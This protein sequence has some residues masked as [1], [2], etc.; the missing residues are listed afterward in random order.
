[1]HITSFYCTKNPDAFNADVS[2]AF[3]KKLHVLLCSEPPLTH[4]A[5]AQT[6][7]QTHTHT[8]THT[9]IYFHCCQGGQLDT[10]LVCSFA[11]YFHMLC[12]WLLAAGGAA[13][14]GPGWLRTS[15][16]WH[17][18]WTNGSNNASCHRRR[19]WLRSASIRSCQ[20]AFFFLLSQHAFL[21]QNS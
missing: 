14:D 7:N 6:C 8:H 3:Q 10:M 19:V 17:F 1:M 4:P 9:L 5:S 13:S 20:A 11:A 2:P 18:V 16:E 21:F 12:V 15:C